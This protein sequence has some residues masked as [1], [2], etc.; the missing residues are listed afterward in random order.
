MTAI[1]ED[2]NLLGHFL[3]ELVKVR[4]PTEPHKLS[5]LEQQY[6]GEEEPSEDELERRG[7]PDGW[8][9]D[10]EGWCVLIESKVIAKLTADQIYRHRRTAERR[11]FES[12]VV[13]A[14]TPHKPTALPPSDPPARMADC[15]RLASSP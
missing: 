6:P 10:N 7:I 8:I 5:V 15:V 11:G 9:Y 13:V 3:R 14:I 4:P 2:R 1:D 12:I